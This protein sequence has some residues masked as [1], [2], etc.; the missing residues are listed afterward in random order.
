MAKAPKVKETIGPRIRNTGIRKVRASELVESDFNFRTHPD[1]QVACFD[2]IVEE[3]G[4]YGYPLCYE[5]PDGRIGIVDGHLRKARL[6]EKYGDVEI[7]VAMTDLS[8]DEAKKALLTIDP[9]A[10]LAEADAAK[11]DALLREVETGNEDLAAMLEELAEEN[12]IVPGEDTETVLKQLE[13]KAPPKMTWCL[14]G[15]PTVRWGEIAETVEGLASVAD[16]IVEMAS[17]DD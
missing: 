9:L 14:I 8:T 17:T 3:Q 2:A 12:G 5:L 4:F 6:L 11:L 16:A 7:E 1:S 10:A 13:T 15:L